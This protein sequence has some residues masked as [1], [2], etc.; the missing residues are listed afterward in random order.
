MAAAGGVCAALACGWLVAS[1]VAEAGSGSLTRWAKEL[2]RLRAEVDRLD[3][4]LRHERARGLSELRALVRRKGELELRVD[5]ERVR[6]R[7]ARESVRELEGKLEKKEKSGSDLMPVIERAAG[8]VRASIERGLPFRTRERLDALADIEARVKS[9]RL[10]PESGVAR[11]WRLVEDELRLAREVL[12]TKAPV[13][14]GGPKRRERRLVR[15]ARLGMVAMF[16][17]LGEGRYGHFV[18]GSDGVWAHR[19][20]RDEGVRGEVEKLFGA[21]ENGVVGRTYEL[22]VPPVEAE[23]VEAQGKESEQERE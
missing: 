5:R 15:V 14:L 6:V 23:R 1:G 4:Q 3:A 13:R 12:L 9:G 16:T 17:E 8:K 2:S 11:L 7:A 20:I 19:T 22:P 18:R 21:L 10:D